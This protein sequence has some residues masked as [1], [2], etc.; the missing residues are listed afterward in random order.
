MKVF[1]LASG[2]SGNAA[3]FA[4]GGTQILVD[5]GISPDTLLDRLSRAGFVPLLDAIVITHA[6]DDHLGQY[7][8]IAEKFNLPVY[9]SESTVR[10]AQPSGQLRLRYFHPRQA[11]EI[12]ALTISPLP[13][14]HDAPQV[15]LT[16]SDGRRKASIATD[17]GEVP[18]ALP[19]HLGHSDIVLIESNHDVEMVDRGPY[20]RHL[21]RRILSARGHLS[22]EQSAELIKTFGDQVKTV[23][24]MHLSKANNRAELALNAAGAALAG[25]RVHLHLAP[26]QGLLE[27][28]TETPRPE[29]ARP[30]EKEN[31]QRYLP[32]IE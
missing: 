23:V 28:D 29:S 14:P 11:F 17:L 12:G 20:P 25:K 22:N 4:S 32:G 19:E 1:V 27:L 26:A 24:L 31:G 3:L 6:H 10:H 16:I 5:A 15:S 30:R 7:K 2:S 21:K 8:R 18:P 13:L 9:M